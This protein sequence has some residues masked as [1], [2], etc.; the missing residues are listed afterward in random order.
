MK[1]QLIPTR[2]IEELFDNYIKTKTEWG[3]KENTE[4]KYFFILSLICDILWLKNISEERRKKIKAIPETYFNWE[5]KDKILTR[6]IEKKQSYLTLKNWKAVST[7]T[8]LN[9]KD[10]IRINQEVSIINWFLSFLKKETNIQIPNLNQQT[11]KHKLEDR[12]QKKII[13]TE[14]SNVF[15]KY[16]LIK[17]EQAQEKYQ[18]YLKQVKKI[19]KEKYEKE[20]NK[21]RKK[22]VIAYQKYIIIYLLQS[23][24]FDME[25]IRHLKWSNVITDIENNRKNQR[26]LKI[27]WSEVSLTI[28]KSYETP[29]YSKSSYVSRPIP[30]WK[31]MSIT[32]RKNTITTIWK[33]GKEH[34]I[35]NKNL[36]HTIQQYRI[37]KNLKGGWGLKNEINRYNSKYILSPID[38]TYIEKQNR[39]YKEAQLSATYITRIVQQTHQELIKMKNAYKENNKE[40]I[41][42]VKLHK[43]KNLLKVPTKKKITPYNF[44][45]IKKEKELYNQYI[46]SRQDLK[47]KWGKLK[48]EVLKSSN[49]E[50]TK[51]AEEVE[52]QVKKARKKTLKLEKELI[53]ITKRKIECLWTSYY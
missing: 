41:N 1:N 21:Y 28:K 27:E 37:V 53:P 48:E 43:L 5:V 39:K 18:N 6:N 26:N 15:L 9:K 19:K 31:E 20:R 49:L 33:Q 29:R 10:K 14:V 7:P 50:K 16:L 3:Q 32:E 24:Y 12:N 34:H 30:K 22:W 44:F 35:H 8:N 17:T 46:K 45:L 4:K 40:I 38:K 36:I 52:K 2:K 25:E 23:G 11:Y 51:E 47:I 13:T 42:F